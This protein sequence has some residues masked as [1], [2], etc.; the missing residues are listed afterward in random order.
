MLITFFLVDIEFLYVLGVS[1]N[2]WERSID[3]SNYNCTFVYFSFHFYQFCFIYWQ[4]WFF[5]A[6]TF[7]TAI[8]YWC[9]DLF[10][11]IF[12][13]YIRSSLPLVIFCALKYALSTINTVTSYSYFYQ[14]LHNISFSILFTLTCLYCYILSGFL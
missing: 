6:Y 4:L 10:F 5:D 8:S 9:I 1:I 12:Y 7:R 11:L 13:F 3:V 14:C 2:C